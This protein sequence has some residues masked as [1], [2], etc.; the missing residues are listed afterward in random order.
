MQSAECIAQKDMIRALEKAKEAGKSER[1]LCKFRENNGLQEQ[2]NLDLTYAILFNLA[3]AHH[4]NKAYDEALNTYNLI[5]KNKNYTQ[6]GRLRIN[7]GNIH[8]EQKKYPQAIKMYRMA[9]DQIPSTGKELRF[10][11]I[12]NIGNSFVKMGQFQDAIESYETVMTGSPDAQTGFNLLLCYFARGDKDKMKRQFQKMLTIPVVG[13]TDDDEEKAGEFHDL[14]SERVDNLREDLMRRREEYHEKILTAA[15]LIGPVIDPKDDW[16]A[17]YRWVMDQVKQ[18]FESIASKL[19][20]D[21]SMQFMKKRQFEE[22]VNVLKSF[23]RKDPSIQAMAATN[24]SFIYFLEED[25]QQAEKH[26]DAAIKADRYNAKALVNKGNCLYMA[27]DAA[28]AKEMYLEAVGVEANCVEALF[29]LGL[30]NLKLN[31]VGEANQA[32]EKLYTI[33]PSAS[34]AL[35]HMAAIYDR[36]NVAADLE[37]A[38]KTY[39]LLLNKVPGDPN[40]CVKLGQVYE[41]LEDENTACHWYSEAH[42]YFPVNLNV[43][44]WLGVWYVK[45]EMY[46]QAIE[47]FSQASRVQPGEVKWRLMVSSC[48]RRLGDLQKS[49]ELYIQIH[50]DFPDNIESLQY[51]EALCKDLGRPSD[52]YTKKLDKLRRQ[53]PV[54][55]PQGTM[56]AP[57]QSAAPPARSARPERSARPGQSSG[58]TSSAERSMK[59]M[60]SRGPSVQSPLKAPSA[61]NGA[62]SRGPPMRKQQAN[63]DEDDFADTDVHDLLD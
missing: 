24:L 7:M 22:A 41:R 46:D 34:E 4:A 5:V 8:Y 38:A 27:G 9:L 52:E 58:G 25:F 13:M 50:E 11:I 2:I 37:Q 28:R 55:G 12:R 40:I 17:G 16:L 49:L 62:A 36:S 48:Y 31:M 3:N 60:E 35:F 45:R 61:P 42:R 1:A 54:S 47:Y 44:S 51:L 14:S 32:F 63:N 26:A 59:E 15:R 43:I 39:E 30:V 57:A 53:L 21:L 10:R 19:E 20:I 18:D 29:N 33:F 23:L 6:S 56:A